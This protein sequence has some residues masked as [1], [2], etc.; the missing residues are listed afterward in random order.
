MN[1]RGR[2]AQPVDA[3]SFANNSQINLR[4]LGAAQTL[5]LVDGRRQPGFPNFGDSA[6]SDL[7]GIPLAAIERIGSAADDGVRHLRRQCDGRRH[8][9]DHASYYEGAEIGVKYEDS[10]SSDAPNQRVDAAA[11]FNLMD[12]KTNVLIAGSYMEGEQP[13]FNEY[14]YWERGRAAILANTNNNYG[15]L[16]ASGVPVLGATTNIR[17]ANGSN[18]VLDNGIALGSAITHVPAGYAG[19][20][21]DG[22]AA[23]VGQAGRYNIEPPDTMHTIGGNATRMGQDPQLKSLSLT[24]RQEVTDDLSL[25]AQASASQSVARFQMDATVGQTLTSFRLPAAAPANPFQQ[26]ILVQVPLTSELLSLRSETETRG[27]AGGLIYKLPR[28][29]VAGLDSHVGSIGAGFSEC[30]C[31][32]AHDACGGGELGQHRRVSRCRHQRCFV[33]VRRAAG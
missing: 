22:G 23:L 9:R 29:W 33:S 30:L 25:F 1:S 20:A 32:P 18:L 5:I 26:D 6:Q 2:D 15:A 8:Q 11:G 3:G 28:N 31:W 4:G 13:R 24:V 16:D 14:R 12:G 17:S 7:N 19:V 10:F 27:L 21:S